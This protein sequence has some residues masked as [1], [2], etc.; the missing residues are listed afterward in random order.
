VSVFVH[1][2]AF[3]LAVAALLGASARWSG[4]LGA[5]GLERMLAAAATAATLIV[6]WWLALA[7]VGL[8][9]STL[10]LVVAAVAT[11]TLARVRV[12][13]EVEAVGELRAWI[14][15]EPA[16]TTIAV[17]ALAGAGLAF[18]AWCLRYPPLGAD[19]ILYH[20][21]ESLAWLHGAHPGSVVQSFYGLPV[22]NYPL[23]AE[24]LQGWGFALSRSFAPAT[25]LMLA[26]YALLVVG[27]WTGLR[28]LDVPLL[29]RALAVAAVALGPLALGVANF[30]ST[31]LPAT[32]WLVVCAALAARAARDTPALLAPALLAGGL[33]IGTKTTALPLAVVVL[34]LAFYAL[35]GRLRPLRRVLIVTGSAAAVVGLFWYARNLVQHG[36]PF[37]PLLAAP[38]GDPVPAVITRFNASLLD[39]PSYTLSGHLDTYSASLAGG[40]ILLAG[41]IVSPLLVRTRDVI[42]AAA[43]ALLSVL[44]WAQAP[45]TGRSSDP[46]FAS[47]AP[48][49]TRYLLPGLC[50]AA[51]VPA[52][53]ARRRGV[54]GW[55]A[56]AL[57]AAATVWSI[58]ESAKHGLPATPSIKTFAL[59]ALAGA[60][61]AALARI[62]R[63]IR[64]PALAAG[65][66]LVLLSALLLR[67]AA[68][69]YVGRFA[70]VAPVYASALAAFDAHHAYAKTNAEISMAPVLFAPL[71]GDRLQHKIALMPADISCAEVERR[72]RNGW[73]V[74]VS[75]VS[76]ATTGVYFNAG[77]CLAGKQPTFR[78][79]SFTAYG[80]GP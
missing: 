29:P 75:S 2:L 16:A 48:G 53:A 56:T 50:A 37:W 31:D 26:S 43:V 13:A 27:G 45:L 64:A 58:V 72:M 38:W 21:P 62:E 51:L 47:I 69:G 6:L 9:G 32:A 61:V 15:R 3:A 19:G 10:A 17:G 80:G 70:R 77:R 34:A 40:V 41:V 39:R 73:V 60:S 59:G 55:I 23:V 79:G 78:A 11:W 46:T 57:L 65:L 74:I 30:P 67:P 24:L 18:A 54:A 42:G 5:R 71:A 20:L 76:E 52:L 35:R 1:Q 25:L 44:L 63:P 66:A 36:S 4:S 8:G 14:A 33:A 28:A 68:E 22:G 7:L 12:R 49:T